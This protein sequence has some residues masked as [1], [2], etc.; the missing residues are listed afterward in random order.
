MTYVSV[1]PTLQFGIQLRGTALPDLYFSIVHPGQGVSP[2]L[3]EMGTDLAERGLMQI[4]EVFIEGQSVVL[5]WKQ[6]ESPAGE[7][8]KSVEVV[9]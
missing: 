4:G 7:S 3:A 9:T 2:V 5:S 6:K 8:S 1:G